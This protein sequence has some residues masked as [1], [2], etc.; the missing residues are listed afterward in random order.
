LLQLAERLGVS[1]AGEM[2]AFSRGP[3]ALLTN[4][5]DAR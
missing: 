5:Y 1:A 4:G 2:V 3:W